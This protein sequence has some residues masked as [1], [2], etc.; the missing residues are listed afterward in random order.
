MAVNLFDANFYRSV[1]PDLAGLNDAQ[2]YQHLISFGLNEGRTFSLYVD[3][4]TYRVSNTD[5]AAAGLITNQQLYDHLSISGAAEGRNFSPVFNANVYRALNPDLQAAGLNNEQLLDHFR[6]FGINEGRQASNSF[7]VGF[8]LAANPDL[9]AA[10][11]NNQQ[12]LQHYVFFGIA[13]GRIAA[14]SV[15]STLSAAPSFLSTNSGQVGTIDRLT[16][17]FTELAVGPSFTDI[18]R[19]ND[20]QLFGITFDELYSINPNTGLSSKIGSFGVSG[21]FNALG[22]S[23]DNRLFA[24][25][26]DQSSIYTIDPLTGTASPVSSIVNLDFK[27]SGDLAFDSNSNQFF[28]VSEELGTEVLFSIGLDG[29][30]TRIG[31]IGF[32]GV[33]GLDFDHGTLFGY[34]PDQQQIVINT[35]TGA[36]TFSQDVTGVNGVIWGAA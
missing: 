29:T 8:Y 23:G 1:N 33:F 31:G 9:Q 16:G 10:G 30:A 18:A 2:A 4:N 14:P 6:A 21:D 36:G 7:S 22:F 15:G 13:E 25:A 12:A 19:S 3:L 17:V 28:A 20:G 32:S 34:T 24:A 11:F 5:L 27:S 35:V 26:R